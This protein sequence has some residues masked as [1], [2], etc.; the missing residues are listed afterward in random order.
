MLGVC[1][2]KASFLLVLLSF[3]GG[4]LLGSGCFEEKPLRRAKSVKTCEDYEQIVV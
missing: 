4:F 1:F 3:C 2:F